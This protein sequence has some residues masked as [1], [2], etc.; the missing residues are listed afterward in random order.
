MPELTYSRRDFLKTTVAAAIVG[1]TF[2][3]APRLALAEETFDPA[4]VAKPGPLGDVVYGSEEAPVTM[5]E[6]SSL[7]CGHCAAFKTR[8][9]PELKEK[10]IDTGKVRYIMREF[11]LDA[12][13]TAGFMMGRALPEDRYPEYLTF[14]FETQKDWA[15]NEKPYSALLK[16]GRQMGLTKEAVDAAITNQTLLEGLTQTRDRAHEE[17]GVSGTPSFFVNGEKVV[18]YRELS[19]WDEIL[20]KH[21]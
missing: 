9:F 6:Y 19:E 13:A 8:V 10:Y 11:P 3:L 17:F 1:A 5:V 16:I 12:V 2:A 7:T 14:M 20:G 15:F 21:L 4:E 18:G